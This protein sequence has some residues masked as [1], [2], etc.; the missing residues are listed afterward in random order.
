MSI[1]SILIFLPLLG[2]LAVAISPIG[3]EKYAKWLTLILSL[4][5]LYLAVQLYFNFE[6]TETGYQ[7]LEH[8]DW[9]TVSLGNLGVISIDYILGVDGISLPMILLAAIIQVIGAIS[10]FEI[11]EKVKGY[12]ATYLLLSASVMGCFLALDFFLFFL[13][14]EFMLLPMYFL[15]GIWGGKN[16]EY[17]SIKFFIYTLVGS[18]FILVAM[19]SIYISAIDPVSTA[20]SLGIIG[21]ISQISP[22]AIG[23][24]QALLA[25][26]QLPAQHLVHTFDLRFL[27]DPANYAPNSI[28][29]TINSSNIFGFEARHFMFLLLFLGFAIKLPL[30]PFHTWLPDAHVEAPTAISVVLAG[31]LLKIGG[32]GLIRIAY[33]IFPDSAIHFS[34][35]IALAGVFS[36]LWGAFNS[37]AQKDLKRQIAFSSVSHMGFV[38]LGIAS[39]TAEGVNGAIFQMFSHGILSAMLFLIVGVLYFRTGSRQIADYQGIAN[40]M[41]VFTLFVAIAFFASL[42]LPAFSG[43]IGE[44]FSLMGSFN[45]I[46]IPKYLTILGALGI[47]IGACYFLWTFRRMFLGNYWIKKEAVLLTDL[48]NYEVIMFISLTIIT[49]AIGLLPNLIFDF[50]GTSVTEF[51]KLFK[52]AL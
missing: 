44:F 4:I 6:K 28:L 47:I 25:K 2:S 49:L 11:K 45:S 19:I 20:Q 23:E 38:V 34:F 12:F 5:G 29:S 26:G 14:F 40:K 15:I 10:S 27:S 52:Q 41:P 9:I 13:F 33:S 21:N 3:F 32:Y 35:W 1:L 24:V 46:L 16:K 39:I 31:T 51:I 8:L 18:I 36:I 7:F 48:K 43:F 30:V 50:T 22:Q 42:G 17:A 37:L